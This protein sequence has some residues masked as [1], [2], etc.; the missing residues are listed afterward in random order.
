M[1]LNSEYQDVNLAD[2]RF[3]R[4][5][6][7]SID[8]I[9]EFEPLIINSQLQNTLN[10][11]K[12]DVIADLCILYNIRVDERKENNITSLLNID[13]DKKERYLFFKILKIEEEVQ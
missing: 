9:M 1:S 6:G 13:L 8:S 3:W 4:E 12:K 10:K 2:K 11:Q 5:L 7:V